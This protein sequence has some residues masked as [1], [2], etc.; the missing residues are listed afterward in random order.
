MPK[1]ENTDFFFLLTQKPLKKG[2]SE[3][4]PNIVYHTSYPYMLSQVVL[5]LESQVLALAQ[6]LEQETLVP[7]QALEQEQAFVIHI[8]VLEALELVLMKLVEQVQA[9]AQVL[10]MVAQVQL[11]VLH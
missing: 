4:N 5:E 11:V 10:D 7:A 1:I 6:V 2:V 9:L 8:L 3:Q